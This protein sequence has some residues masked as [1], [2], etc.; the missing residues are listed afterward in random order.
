MRRR[1]PESSRTFEQ[2]AFAD[3]PRDFEEERLLCDVVQHAENAS[4]W[5]EAAAQRAENEMHLHAIRRLGSVGQEENAALAFPQFGKALLV[6]A[7]QISPSCHAEVYQKLL[8]LGGAR[9]S[10]NN[11]PDEEW[12]GLLQCIERMAG[13]YASDPE[14]GPLFSAIAK[15]E[16]SWMESTRTHYAPEDDE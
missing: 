11:E 1:L 15:H 10:T 8:H 3:E 6:R 9:G 13:E 2:R 7:R 4:E 12:K 16:R 5:L 14:L